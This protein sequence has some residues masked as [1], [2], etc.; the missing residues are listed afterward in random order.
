MTQRMISHRDDTRKGRAFFPGVL[1][2]KRACIVLILALLVLSG[3]ATPVGI[4]Y[5]DGQESYLN[6][7]ANVLTHSTL[8]APTTQILNRNGLA[9]RFKSHP[10]E[11]IA[12]IHRGVSIE[13]EADRLFAL[14]ELSFLH[15]SQ[16]EDRS[17]Y[18]ASAIYAYTLLFPKDFSRSLDGF[19][20][21]FR[22][23]VDIY[24]L[25]IAAGLSSSDG[26]EVDLTGGT[27]RL[28]F[29]EFTLSVNPRSFRWSSYRLVSFVNASRLSIRGLRNEY[30]WPGIGAALVAA[31]KYVSVNADPVTAKVP[32]DVKVAVTAFIRFDDP[33]EGLKRGSLTGKLELYTTDTAT[34]VTVEGRTVPLEFD[35]SSAVAASLEGS[36]VYKTEIKGFFSGNFLFFPDQSRFRENIFFMSPYR[37]GH[38]PVVFIHGTASSPARWMEMVNELQN[39]RRLWGRYQFWSFTYNTGNPI[40]YSGGLLTEG[41]K[42]VVRALD[43]HG[44]D[45][46]LKE[47]VIIGHSQG[48]LLTKLAVIDSGTRFWDATSNVPFGKLDVSDNTR[49]MLGRSV[50][51][52]PLPFVRRVIFI[53]TP[54]R[55][56]YVAGG[57]I[58][59]L[60]GK[61]ISLPF[62]MVE[63]MK[64]VVTRNPD[65]VDLSTLEGVPRSTANMDPVSVFIKVF[66]SIPIAPGVP[67]HSII[68]V[69]NPDAP[70]AK[71]TDGVVKYESAHLDGAAS[72]LVVHS[73]HSCQSEPQTIEEVRR[74]LLLHI[75]V[76]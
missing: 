42:E 72:E 69:R 56:S 48:G 53:S 65:A 66:S 1:T 39:D 76:Q 74:I 14:A 36:E 10:A 58:G 47:M 41:L 43:P 15:A 8:S 75:G 22:T 18:L 21:R 5:L 16:S 64:E 52:K 17:Y 73:G 70:K 32:P 28:P 2:R 31:T 63:G 23:A 45:P 51:Y 34:T 44:R 6:L 49:E 3:C 24:N 37:Q 61:F 7:T 30:R 60:A 25:G 62:R 27:Y 57:W 68:S 4:G 55:G 35:T 12:S 13:N 26:L 19:D 20:P 29:G 46:A 67:A 33:D 9:Q 38:I 50:F 59:R 11:V 71:W 54:H 40:L